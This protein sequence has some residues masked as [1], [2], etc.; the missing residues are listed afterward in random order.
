MF[1]KNE[2][3]LI[4]SVKF[5]DLL[6]LLAP[7]V[8]IDLDADFSLN[9]ITLTGEQQKKQA[10]AWTVLNNVFYL[11]ITFGDIFLNEIENLWASLVEGNTPN[12]NK[13]KKE[14]E[15]RQRVQTVINYLVMMILHSKNVEVIY[16]AKVFAM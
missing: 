7:W 6:L 11:T 16:F 3:K 15:Y 8:K 10:V 12:S 14:K 4:N 5:R 13:K 2:P 9:P 1:I